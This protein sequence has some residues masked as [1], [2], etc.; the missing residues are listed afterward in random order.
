M[1]VTF[2]FDSSATLEDVQQLEALIE[3]AVASF[4]SNHANTVYHDVIGTLDV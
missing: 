1:S 3:Q 2:K 4:N